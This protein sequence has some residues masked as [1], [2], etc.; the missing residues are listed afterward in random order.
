ME[1]YVKWT[2]RVLSLM[3]KLKIF[4]KTLQMMLKNRF[5]K[6]NYEI[7]RPLPNEENKKFVGLMNDELGGKIMT[8]C[9]SLTKDLILFNEL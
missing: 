4:I 1:N 9:C 7:N 6:S 8:I 3:L 2:L 5:D